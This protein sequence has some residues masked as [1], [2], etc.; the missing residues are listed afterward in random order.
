MIRSIFTQ[1]RRNVVLLSVIL[2]FIVF[3]L[4]ILSIPQW[5]F[6]GEDFG[7]VFRASQITSI[8]DF[9]SIFTHG[10]VSNQAPPDLLFNFPQT[11]A[12]RPIYVFSV[13]LQFILFKTNAI[14]YFWYS[15]LLHAAICSL[16]F[17]LVCRFTSPLGAFLGSLFFAFNPKLSVFIGK[18][19]LQHQKLCLLFMLISL[20]FLIKYIDK[21]KIKFLILSL[22]AF[23]I[24]LLSREIFIVFPFLL[25]LFIFLYRKNINWHQKVYPL[26]GFFATS[27]L[28][29]IINFILIP[30]PTNQIAEP[31][32]L[33]SFENF[34]YNLYFYY[35]TTLI[36]WSSYFFFKMFNLLPIYALLKILLI[37]TPI[38]LFFTNTSKKF[39]LFL[40]FCTTI[41]HWPTLLCGINGRFWYEPALLYIF[42]LIMLYE[43]SRLQ[44]KLFSIVGTTLILLLISA[45]AAFVIKDHNNQQQPNNFFHQELISL[46]DKLKTK[47]LE[48][49]PICFIE[50]G[51][52]L[53][54]DICGLSQAIFLYKISTSRHIYRRLTT[55]KLP[56]IK[57]LALI[58]WDKEKRSFIILNDN[59]NEFSVLPPATSIVKF[60]CI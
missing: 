34:W 40:L 51:E 17:F 11:T 12:Y 29:L 22:L 20:I 24:S 15:I 50:K 13:W 14:Y 42:A 23:F 41:L 57:P 48:H 19:D 52:K 18:I 28:F 21:L 16:F 30:S 31:I 6:E 49:S 1:S 39:I 45:N 9:L 3:L 26:I 7:I 47:K 27:F 33:S 46:Q 4:F 25:A 5:Y 35:L 55:Q 36:P 38:I 8:K 10:T 32:N 54:W 2:F 37:V 53:S 43:K 60:A 58:F 44:Y 59:S 56:Q